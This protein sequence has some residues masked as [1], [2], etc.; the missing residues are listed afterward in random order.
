MPHKCLG[1]RK[2]K[3]REFIRKNP[4]ATYR[5][6][7]RRLCIKIERIYKGGMG[8]AFKDAGIEAPRTFKRRTKE[9]RRKIIIKYIKKHPGA[10][11]RAILR[12]TKINVSNAFSS[13]R[14][15]YKEAGVKYPR[16]I[17]ERS[18]EEKEKEIIRLVKENPLITVIELRKR[19]KTNPYNFFKN[20]K[21]IYKKAGRKEINNHEKR[22]ANIKERVIE[23]IKK[24]PLTTQREI[25]KLCRTHVQELFRGGIFGAYREAGIKFP[26]ERLKLYGTVLKEI[27]QRARTFE[28]RIAVKLS[29]YGKVNKLVKT[30]RGFAN[31]IFEKKNKRVVIEIKD[32]KSKDISIS[33]IKQLN[34]YLEDC[35]CNL[36]LLI[37][38]KKPKKDKFLIGKNRVLVLEESELSKIPNLI[39]GL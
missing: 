10:G 35:N 29:R 15:A 28:E 11:R 2:E 6:I 13:I 26:H 32:Y 1:S 22:R 30:K 21:E 20:M 8:E 16:K 19:T 24:H 12:D 31:I 36:G 33:Q 3:I 18:R 9:E 27:K 37:C 7:K 25:N 5:D 38:H 14:E 39:K 23:F 4:K 17:D 34:R